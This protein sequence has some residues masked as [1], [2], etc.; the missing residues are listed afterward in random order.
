MKALLLAFLFLTNINASESFDLVATV[1]SVYQTVEDAQLE[2][3]TSLWHQALSQC[4]YI[5]L[6]FLLSKIKHTTKFNG[7]SVKAVA[8]FTCV[9]GTL[10]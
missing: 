1:H 10:Q 4:T 8:S 3:E 6:P 7:Q 2:A 9:E 5:G